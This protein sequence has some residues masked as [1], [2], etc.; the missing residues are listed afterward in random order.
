MS[1]ADRNPWQAK[2]PFQIKMLDFAVSFH[3]NEKIK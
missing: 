3:G 1:R 2:M